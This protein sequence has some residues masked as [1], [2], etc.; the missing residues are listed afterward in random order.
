MSYLLWAKAMT[1][2]I[3]WCHFHL[4]IATTQSSTIHG[5]THQLIV[6][7]ITAGC[8]LVIG[9]W[10]HLI[11]TK[12]LV[13]IWSALEESHSKKQP[14]WATFSSNTHLNSLVILWWWKVCLTV[15]WVETSSLQIHLHIWYINHISNTRAS[16]THSLCHGYCLM[17]RLTDPFILLL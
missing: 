16:H 2:D 5:H 13:N 10:S 3:Y 12:A 1:I 4:H 11:T 8:L 7:W 17:N 14:A 15:V 9:K 6:W